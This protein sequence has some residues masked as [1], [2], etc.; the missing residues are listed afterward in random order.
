[1]LIT[2]LLLGVA[3]LVAAAVGLLQLWIF[4]RSV[5]VIPLL[6]VGGVGVITYAAV[7]RAGY[8]TDARGLLHQAQFVALSGLI[9][10]GIFW[11]WGDYASRTGSSTRRQR[12]PNWPIAQTSRC[13][14]P[15]TLGL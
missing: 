5:P 3:M 9:A 2:I 13:S 8:A 15:Q 1:M 12:R 4:P 10:G 14:A 11:A 7:L 6:I